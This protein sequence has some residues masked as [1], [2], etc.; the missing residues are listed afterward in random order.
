M[1]LVLCMTIAIC[2]VN[3]SAAEFDHAVESDGV[4]IGSLGVA[5]VASI[6]VLVYIVGIGI[7]VTPIDNK[8]IPAICGAVGIVFG[9]VALYAGVPGFPAEDIITASAVGGASGLAATG[10]NQIAKQLTQ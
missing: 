5:T 3:V 9:I 8:W 2:A 1:L 4:D 10:I 7:R 6:T